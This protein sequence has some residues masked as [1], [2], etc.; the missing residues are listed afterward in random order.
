MT[1]SYVDWQMA[2]L[3]SALMKANSEASIAI[4]LTLKNA[5][6][7]R[8]VLVAAAEMTRTGRNREIFDA[9]M[10]IYGGLQS[11]RADIAHGIFGAINDGQPWW[12]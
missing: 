3:L 7:Q 9:I 5:Q 4:F 6:A 2:I 10:L 12:C 8:E 11:Q 1:W